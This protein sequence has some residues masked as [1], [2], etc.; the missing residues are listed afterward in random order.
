M[1]AR[2]TPFATQ[3][4]REARVALGSLGSRGAM[5]FYPHGSLTDPH[6]TQRRV[7]KV[8]TSCVSVLLICKGPTPQWGA[9]GSTR[10]FVRCLRVSGAPKDR[11]RSLRTAWE[12]SR[13]PSKDPSRD[14][15]GAFTVLRTR[16][17]CSAA[18]CCSMRSCMCYHDG[19]WQRSPCRFCVQALHTLRLWRC[20][21]WKR[22][23]PPL[24]CA[25]TCATLPALLLL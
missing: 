11:M 19:R 7:G 25:Q 4:R 18:C 9:A 5:S 6:P 15:A 22:G 2:L 17:R 10:S 24:R 1:A 16:R 21:T 23:R 20:P 12:P 3:E 13:D 14:P 8:G